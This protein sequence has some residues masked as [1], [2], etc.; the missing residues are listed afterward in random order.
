M[1]DTQQFGLLVMSNIKLPATQQRHAF[2][3]TAMKKYAVYDKI[4]SDALLNYIT[5][6]RALSDYMVDN[7]QNAIDNH[8]LLV[9]YTTNKIADCTIKNIIRSKNYIPNIHILHTYAMNAS[10]NNYDVFCNEVY[11][12]MINKLDRI[13]TNNQ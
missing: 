7:N 12:K 3:I 4:M 9:D 8:E 6:N 5:V 11:K 10:K 1:S 2:T 13:L